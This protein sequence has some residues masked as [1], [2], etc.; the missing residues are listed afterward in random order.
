MLAGHV[1]LYYM[2]TSM[3]RGSV[4]MELPPDYVIRHDGPLIT[5][6]QRAS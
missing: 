2:V 3:M 5:H 6:V 4:I 1:I